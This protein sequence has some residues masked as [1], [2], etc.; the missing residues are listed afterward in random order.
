MKCTS[1]GDESYAGHRASHVALPRASEKSAAGW[2]TKRSSDVGD[3]DDQHQRA[4]ETADGRVRCEHGIVP[5]PCHRQQ[6]LAR[7]SPKLGAVKQATTRIPDGKTILKIIQ[8]Q[9]SPKDFGKRLKG[10]QL[11]HASASQIQAIRG[12]TG[13]R[14]KP[15][16]ERT[17]SREDLP[18]L[19]PG[20]L[21]R[22]SLDR[23]SDHSRRFTC[24][25]QNYRSFTG[26][27]H[28]RHTEAM[29][30]RRHGRSAHRS[31]LDLRPQPPHPRP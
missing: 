9:S 27:E 6:R 20:P 14:I 23:D 2:R 16:T 10:T 17:K 30:I 15:V 11:Q 26:S 7:V 18:R 12:V 31:T 13:S 29:G 21:Q 4:T 24:K 5:L 3:Q 22:T 28:A 19:S 25:N 1:V 8:N